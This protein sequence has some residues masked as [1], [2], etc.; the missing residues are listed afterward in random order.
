MAFGLPANEELYNRVKMIPTTFISFREYARLL[1]TD[2]IDE[3]IRYGGILHA[4]EFDFDNKEL[5][6]KET[7]SISTNG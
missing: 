1:H 7:Y 5:P 3:Y 4:E 6:A 2:S